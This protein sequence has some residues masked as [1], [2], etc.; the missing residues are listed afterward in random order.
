MTIKELEDKINDLKADH[1]RLSG[2]M[3]KLVYVGSNPESTEKELAQ[4]ESQISELRQQ[5]ADAKKS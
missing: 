1:M 3:E 2:D 4:L 5:L